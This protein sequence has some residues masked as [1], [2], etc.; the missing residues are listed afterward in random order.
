MLKKTRLLVFY[1]ILLSHFY[2]V[3]QLS[4]LDSIALS[5]D[6]ILH[7]QADSLKKIFAADGFLI[8]REATI[9]MISQYEKPVVV[10]FKA[11]TLYR[12]CF[13]GDQTSRIYEL[14]MYDWEERKMVHLRQKPKDEHGNLI[15]YDYVPHFTELHM[16][17]PI[18]INRKSKN[19]KGY[20]MLFK[21][22][23]KREA[24]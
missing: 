20:M 17:K 22:I 8:L 7:T 2:A 23:M 13:I 1:C 3:G 15:I 11:G 9:A 4:V 5:K 14:R 12:V 6:S 10:S 21:K 18:Q 16:I 24:D 19:I